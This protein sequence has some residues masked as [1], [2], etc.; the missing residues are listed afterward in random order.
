L[1]SI[2]WKAISS[3]VDGIASDQ[4]ST[5]N[6]KAYRPALELAWRSLLE[7]DPDDLARNALAI[8]DGDRLVVRTFGKDCA[9]DLSSRSANMEGKVLSD[10]ATL[11]VLHYLISAGPIVPTG[12]WIS[13]RQLPG[14]EA[15][16]LAFKRRTLDELYSLFNRRPEML[17]S[18]MKA[19][20]A[21]RLSFGDASV[22]IDVFPKLP[23]A[24]IIWRGDHEVE[25]RANLSFRRD[26]RP[27]H[28]GGGP[29]R[30]RLIC[31]DPAV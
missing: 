10:K 22:A 27:V 16:Y 14:G 31:P 7:N 12:R 17:F 4:P 13:Y 25:G 6:G 26:R 3:E 28:A 2:L 19:V 30:G 5:L 18:A 21:R 15:Y 8:R 29:G 23:V 24:A 9:V 1:S 11:L 20:G